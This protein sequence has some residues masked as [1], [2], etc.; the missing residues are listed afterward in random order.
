MLKTA[1]QC[2]SGENYLRILRD[3]ISDSA[4]TT[5]R[6][7]GINA[8]VY[9]RHLDTMGLIIAAYLLLLFYADFITDVNFALTTESAMGFLIAQ[10]VSIVLPIATALVDNLTQ[11]C[12]GKVTLAQAARNF[13]LEMSNLSQ[14][15]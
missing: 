10:V 6:K 14:I 9:F 1:S 3:D 5:L 4:L 2:C 8:V 7:T 13:F 12:R 11:L 15:Q